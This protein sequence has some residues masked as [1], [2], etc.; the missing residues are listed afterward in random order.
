MLHCTVVR[1][2]DV[3]AIT[4]LRFGLLEILRQKESSEVFFASTKLFQNKDTN[5]RRSAKE[6]L[7]RSNS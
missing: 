5:L 7:F 6:M 2:T 3:L 4:Y 1:K